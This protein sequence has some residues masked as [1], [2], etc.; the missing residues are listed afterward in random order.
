M[1][2]S[3]SN[4]YAGVS[5]RKVRPVLEHLPGRSVE[6][7]LNLLKFMPTPHARMVAKIVKSAAANAENNYA[8][9]TDVLYVK[10]AVANDARRLSR[11]RP[12]AR[13][14]VHR[15]QRRTSHITIVVDER[16]S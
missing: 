12:A 10:R 14:R 8:M 11:G 13:G 2:V 3:A 1:E 9:D 16:E 4:R 5:P 7:A 6:D 15:Y